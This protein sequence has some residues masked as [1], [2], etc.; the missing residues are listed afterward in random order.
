MKKHVLMIWVTMLISLFTTKVWANDAYDGFIM[1]QNGSIIYIR[2]NYDNTVW[3]CAP[4]NDGTDNGN[5]NGFTKPYGDIVIP[6]SI[7]YVDMWG[8]GGWRSVVYIGTNA[9]L[10]CDEI[11]SIVI[12]D[13]VTSIQECAFCGCTSLTSISHGNN[14]NYIGYSA[15]ADCFS[16]TS[17]DIPNGVTQL[18]WGTFFRCTELTS[19][20]IPSSVTNIA[21][22]TSGDG[23]F[24]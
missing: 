5:W 1:L 19:I 15:F 10:D 24:E 14:I 6:D 12:P 8:H 21:N 22:P 20:Y 7:W 13:G 18:E 17:F 11:T 9:F 16:L 4:N 23:V 3:I 2:D